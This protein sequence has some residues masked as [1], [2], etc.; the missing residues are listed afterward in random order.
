MVAASAG[1]K[2]MMFLSCILSVGTARKI[3]IVGRMEVEVCGSVGD[4]G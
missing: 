4:D 3:E 2:R 1:S